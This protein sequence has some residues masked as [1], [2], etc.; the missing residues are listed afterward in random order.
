M[1]GKEQYRQLQVASEQIAAENKAEYERRQRDVASQ[2]GVPVRVYVCPTP[3][4][5]NFF[6]GSDVGDLASEFTGVRAEDR[7]D[8]ARKHGSPWRHTRAACP[9]CRARGA[10]VER[11]SVVVS[12]PLPDPVPTPP[13]P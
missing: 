2:G 9:D 12:V 7:G 3:G 5:G 4:C 6:G 8:Y 13:L 11:V 1:M 10:S